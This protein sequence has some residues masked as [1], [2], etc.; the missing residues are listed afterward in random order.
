M[1]KLFSYVIQRVSNKPAA[2]LAPLF[3]MGIASSLL[4]REYSFGGLVVACF[5]LIGASFLALRRNRL[6]LSLMLGLSAIAISGLLMA[7]AHR[8]GFAESDLR[9]MLARGF[10]DSHDPMSFEGCA[11]TESEPR[12]EESISTIE[13]HGLLQKDRWIACQGKGILRIAEPDREHSLAP[14]VKLTRGDR[15]RG[16]ASWH[17]PYNYENPGSADMV[18][19]LA[20]RGI[21][22][23]GRAKSS[24]LLEIIP[25]DCSDPWTKLATAAGAHVRASFEPIKN[26]EH[27]QPAAI[28]ASLVIGDYSGLNNFTREVFQNSGTF[29]VLVVSGLH[30]AWIAGM[31]LQLFKLIRMPE[32]I[33]Y[34]LAAGAIFLYTCIIGFQASVTRCLWMFILYLIGR[35]LFRKAD[36]LNILLACALILLGLQPDWLFEVGFQLSFLSVTAIAMTAV[37]VINAYIKP[38]WAPLCHSGDPKRLFMQPGPWYR[39]GRNLRARCEMVIEEATDRLPI[40]TSRALFWICRGIATVGLSIGSALAVSVSVQIWLEPLLAYSFNRMSWISPLANLAIVPFSSIVLAAGIIASSTAGIPHYGPLMIRFAGFLASLLLSEAVLITKIPGAWQR[41][42]TPSAGWILGGILLLFVWSFFEWRR[43]WIPCAFIG[44]LLACLSY[45][46]VPFL[47]ILRKDFGLALHNR[48]EEIWEKNASVLSFTFLDVGEGDSIVIHF[49]D[50]RVWLMD[51]GGLRTTQSQEDNTLAFDIGEAVVSRYLWHE[52]TTH[53]DRLILSHTD[54][55]HSGGMPAI[56]KNFRIA[57]F[58]Y[59]A[60]RADSAILDNI[61]NIAHDQGIRV[62]L[63][64]AGMEEIVGMVTVRTIHPPADSRQGSA[65]ENS[66]TLQFIFKHFSALLTGDLEKSG[67]QDVLSQPIDMHSELLKVGHHGSRFGTS[68]DF[69]DRTQPQWAIVSAGRNNTFGHPSPEVLARL[70]HHNARPIL[71]LDEGAVTFET[72]GE[73]YAIK[74]HIRG[75]IERGELKKQWSVVSKPLEL[76]GH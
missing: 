56:M 33:R 17:A 43:F 35:T 34:L 30:V 53:L 62:N 38:V 24:R 10:F 61:L 16:W 29:H 63:R 8:D 31:L 41:C 1:D 45:G 59:S 14:T 25:G 69:L 71:T 3:S 23:I 76:N 20:R 21:F 48:K 4:C 15:V 11:V 36:A 5:S 65:N 58:N 19:L 18:G 67:E 27:G 32:Q 50:T 37:P 70:L 66:L 9:S 12:G 28:L 7:L 68:N 72:D 49:P 74:T 2:A 57:K 13:L 75:I 44:I 73:R 60:S 54:S 22:I 26:R 52:W 42:P 46:A 39:R 55:D 40:V 6:T 47:E 64:Q 51:A